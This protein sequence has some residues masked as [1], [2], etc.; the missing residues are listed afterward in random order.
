MPDHHIHPAKC[1]AG[2][3]DVS[4]YFH[5]R[6]S[7]MPR[8]TGIVGFFCSCLRIPGAGRLTVRGPASP[9]ASLVGAAGSCDKPTRS[10]TG[11]LT[12]DGFNRCS[13]VSGP[14]ISRTGG[15]LLTSDGGLHAAQYSVHEIH[16][17]SEPQ[18]LGC[19]PGRV[20]QNLF[21]Q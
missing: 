5:V 8:S 3:P 1:C 21:Q 11:L 19:R 17:L 16:G 10:R 13:T 18:H 20:L 12:A 2:T 15:S 9:T 6:D 4:R 7:R 14:D